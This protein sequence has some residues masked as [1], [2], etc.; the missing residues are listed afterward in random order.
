[1]KRFRTV[2]ERFRTLKNAKGRMED[3]VRK[4]RDGMV[5]LSF[6]KR[7][8]ELEAF[9]KAPSHFKEAIF[10][11]IWLLLEIKRDTKLNDGEIF[12]VN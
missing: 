5:V 12:I 6:L 2:I 10:S 3:G 4:K 9:A 7:E 11:P 8:F 1:M